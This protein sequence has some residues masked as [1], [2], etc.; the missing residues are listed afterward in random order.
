MYARTEKDWISGSIRAAPSQDPAVLVREY[1]SVISA[2][3]MLHKQGKEP[4]PCVNYRPTVNKYTRDRPFKMEGN[5]HTAQWGEKEMFMWD[6]D[7]SKA[8]N[9]V[10][11][12]HKL[13]RFLVIDIGDPPEGVMGPHLPRFLVP[14]ALN[15]GYKLSPHLFHLVSHEWITECRSQPHNLKVSCYADDSCGGDRDEGKALESYVKS[16]ELIEYFGLVNSETKGSS[17]EV[18]AG[19]PAV[20]KLLRRLGLLVSTETPTASSSCRRTRRPRSCAWLLTCWRMLS[21][22]TATCGARKWSSTCPP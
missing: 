6:R 2:S 16:G 12:G 20:R 8:F 9:S 18:A 22:H 19:R 10:A 14:L 1:G 15:F 17:A 4:R 7:F 13:Q 3:F 5:K 11:T 21:T